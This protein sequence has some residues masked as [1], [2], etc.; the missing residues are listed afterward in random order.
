MDY[1]DGDAQGILLCS[2]PD[3]FG[4]RREIRKYIGGKSMTADGRYGGGFN[5]WDCFLWPQCS[6]SNIYV[7]I[8]FVYRCISSSVRSHWVR[9]NSY[10]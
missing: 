10:L 4:L 1:D 9:E 6:M 3:L 2:P 8:S 5:P 7:Y